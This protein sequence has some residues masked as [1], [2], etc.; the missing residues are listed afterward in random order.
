MSDRGLERIECVEGDLTRERVD[1]VVNAANPALRGGGGVDG[2]IH[3]AA[4]PELLAELTRRYPDGCPPGEARLTDGHGLAARYVI[5]AV[6]PIWRGGAEG[7]PELLAACH[8]NSLRLAAEHDAATVSFPAISCG[9]YGYPPELAA[10]TAVASIAGALAE[11]AGI[12][13]VRLVLFT[14][15]LLEVFQSALDAARS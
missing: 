10:G 8:A 3:G 5:H 12:E 13:R 11:H 14:H 6:G 4:G 7:E 1:A 2:A 15:E 9:A